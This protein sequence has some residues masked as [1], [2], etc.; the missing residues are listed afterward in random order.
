[1]LRYPEV[2]DYFYSLVELRLPSDD[3]AR[4]VQPPFAAAGYQDRGYMVAEP[5]MVGSEK[6]R[7]KKR[8]DSAGAMGYPPGRVMMMRPPPPPQVPSPPTQH[9]EFGRVPGA[10]YG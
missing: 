9:P 3:D 8:R 10:Y 4:V 2:L 1:M 6:V 7:R 5:S